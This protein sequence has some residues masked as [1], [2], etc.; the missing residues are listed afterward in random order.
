MTRRSPA[1]SRFLIVACGWLA[2]TLVAAGCKQGTGERC[3]WDGDCESGDICDRGANNDTANGVCRVRGTVIPQADAGNPM[4]TGPAA[5]DAETD[6]M[7][8]DSG[9]ATDAPPPPADAAVD[10]TSPAEAGTD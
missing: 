7:S 8:T 6:L 10:V 1:S 2:L 3:E 4:D 5:T 9:A